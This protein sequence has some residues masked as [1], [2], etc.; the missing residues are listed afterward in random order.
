MPDGSSCSMGVRQGERRESVLDRGQRNGGQTPAWARVFA[1]AATIAASASPAWADAAAGLAWLRA[2]QSGEGD[3]SRSTGLAPR[4]S[5]EA[6][7]TLFDLDHHDPD[8][9]RAADALRS[10]SSDTVDL[11]ARR[12]TSLRLGLPEVILE[13]ELQALVSAG[14]AGG[15]WGFDRQA[16]QA[17]ALDTALALR[18]LVTTRFLSNT[19]LLAGLAQLQALQSAEGGFSQAQGEAADVATTAEVL[20]A[21]GAVGVVRDVTALRERAA[22]FLIASMNAD[23]GFPGFRGESSDPTMTALA[24]SALLETGSDVSALAPARAYLRAAQQSDGSWAGDAYT[25]ALAVRVLGG[26]KADLVLQ[27]L[28]LS[29]ASVQQGTPVQVQVTVRNAGLAPSTAA[30]LSLFAGD[31]SSN[32]AGLG[33]TQMPALDVGQSF[34][35]TFTVQTAALSGTVA[36]F[37][38]A[39][40]AGFVPEYSETNNRRFALL[41]VRPLGTLPDPSTNQ[42]PIITNIAPSTAISGTLYSHAVDAIDPESQTLQYRLVFHDG[43]PAPQGMVMDSGT[44]VLT[45]MAGA[46]GVYA[47]TIR[48]L[49]PQG[50][51]AVQ[52]VSL[53]VL[54][55]GEKRPPVFESFPLTSA[56]PGLLYAYHVTARDPDGGPLT[57]RLATAPA[58]MTF[59][60]DTST[61]RWTPTAT[62]TGE[63]LVRLIATDDEGT[64]ADQSWR[65]VVDGGPTA[66][67]DLVAM[68]VD[69]S[70]RRTDRQNLAVGGT[71]L[72]TVANQGTAAAPAFGLALYEDRDGVTGLSAQDAVV[73]R[74]TVPGLAPGETT[75]VT[76][77]LTGT[78]LF[79]DNRLIL[80]VDPDHEVRE[81]R[82]DNNVRASGRGRPLLTVPGSFAP[83]LKLDHR[84]I[85][86]TDNLTDVGLNSPVLVAQL[87]DDN[88]DGKIGEGDT[89]DLLYVVY[90]FGNNV[91]RGPR[92]RAIN[93][94][95]GALIFQTSYLVWQH[96][97]LAVGDVD[98]DGSPDIFAYV[99][100]G[101]G[102]QSLARI[103]KLGNLVWTQ[104]QNEFS[105]PALADLDGDGISEIIAGGNIFEANGTLRCREPH[106]GT[107]GYNVV[108]ADLDLDG[109]PEILSGYDVYRGDCSI[110]RT[111]S[112]SEGA[113]NGPRTFNAVAQLDDDPQPEIIQ[114][115]GGVQT[116]L[117]EHDGTLK[118]TFPSAPLSGAPS[119]GDLD[120]DGKAEIV[121]MGGDRV[122]ALGANGVVRWTHSNLD[123]TGPTLAFS[124]ADLDGDGRMEAML[125]EGGHF[126]IVRGTDGA[127][128]FAGQLFS[129]TGSEYITVADADGDGRTD[130]I[131]GN[132]ENVNSGA[133]DARGIRVWGDPRWAAARPL[134]NQHA[135]HV[136][137]IGCDQ[138]MPRHEPPQWQLL[139]SYLA[140]QEIPDEFAEELHCE[141]GPADL[142]VSYIRIDR[143]A[144]AAQVGY[145]VRVG[146]GGNRTVRPGARV[147]F[148]HAAG[149]GDPVSVGEVQ[150]TRTLGPGQFEDVR[151]TTAAPGVGTYTIFAEIA[152]GS[153]AADDP[154]GNNSHATSAELCGVE[155]R[156]P[157][158]TSAPLVTAAVGVPYAY[159]PTVNDPDQD[160]TTLTLTTAPA[161][162]QLVD[163]PGLLAWTPTA[164]QVGPHPVTLQV[165]DGRGGLAVQDFVVVVGP[166]PLPETAP[167]D[168]VASLKLQASTDKASYA[169]NETVQVSVRIDNT[170]GAGRTGTLAVE[171]RDATGA[172]IETLV[173][174][175]TVL[176]TGTGS[177][178]FPATF[179]VGVRRPGTL[180]VRASYT[181]G[182]AQTVAMSELQILG[183][184]SV[185]ALV[186]TDK[187]VY[188][189]GQT[190]RVNR[191]LTNPGP[192]AEEAGLVALVEVVDASNN[193]LMSVP[194]PPFTLQPGVTSNRLVSFATTGRPAG[195]YRARL[196]V[197]RAGADV[198]TDETIFQIQS[199]GHLVGGLTV[200]PSS[201]QIGDDF[202]LTGQLSNT[203]TAPLALD[204]VV[205]ILDVE[206]LATVRQSTTT[207]SLAAGADGSVSATFSSQGLA[208]K[209][210]LATIEL[211]ENG[212]PRLL[213]LSE[214]F[215]VVDEQP[216]V[217][218]IDIPACSHSPLTPIVNVT[219]PTLVS[220]TQLLDGAPYDGSPVTTEATHV[221]AV[222]ARD[223]AG[224]TSSAS[225]SF[226]VDD[227]APVIGV[228]GVSD[229]AAYATAVTPV[230][231]FDDAN[232]LETTL[233]LD[234]QPFASGAAVEGEGDHTLLATAQDCA[235]NPA[236]RQVQFQIDRTAPVVTIEVP[237]CS[238]GPVTPTITVIEAHVA[239]DVRKLDGTPY[240]G[241][242]VTADGEHEL[243]VTVTDRAGNTNPEPRNA[244]FTVDS[245]QPSVTISGVVDGATYDGPV[246]PVIQ[247][248]DSHLTTSTIVLNG[249][250]FDSGT[251]VSAEGTYTL[252]VTAVDCAGNRSN[253]SVTFTIRHTQGFAGELSHELVAGARVLVATECSSGCPPAPAFLRSV[254]A[255]NQIPFEQANGRSEWLTKL[256]S[257]RFNL[258]V[259]YR[260]QTLESETALRELNEAVW[261]GD[262]LVFIK[263]QPDAMPRLRES[264]GLDFQGNL[265]LTSA[266]LTAPL[267]PASVNVTGGGA[268]LKLSGARGLGVAT[269]N[270]SRTVAASNG[271]GLGKSV[272]LAWNAETSAS[273]PLY[274]SALGIAAPASGGLLPG[275]VAI[276]RANVLNKGPTTTTFTVDHVLGAGLL[277]SDPLTHTLT[278]VPTDTGTFQLLLRLPFQ[279]GT[280]TLTGT[281]TAQGQT[282]DTDVFSMQVDRSRGQIKTD[283]VTA[284]QNL[285]L[286]GGQA[287]R[288]NSA[289]SKINQAAQST[290]AATAIGLV[291]DAIEDV[292]G[293]TAVDVTAIR[294]DLARLLRA[295]QLGWQP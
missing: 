99:P 122:Y 12:L 201:V 106:S 293:I 134:W 152:P 77:T 110:V 211:S 253:P 287:T 155:N 27:S 63:Q 78:G 74:A 82:E 244:L 249:A 88:G 259:L 107:T 75:T 295:H 102:T 60:P 170:S 7:R 223:G 222:T 270:T 186:T 188:A 100:V 205:S 76:V 157:V 190:V 154:P 221:L 162:M 218:S 1:V 254:L 130:L 116:R 194:E 257:G 164:A 125:M 246:V 196:V 91:D 176:F 165:S 40:P 236:T 215:T 118:W 115:V 137:N 86:P 9:V 95:T 269:G 49:D 228:S 284:L 65:V 203:G 55:P 202:D 36:L 94:R 268:F 225:V 275:G 280:F 138:T 276:V 204:A 151:V 45:W 8:F 104:T 210:Y 66:S 212:G 180:S 25:T 111:V 113:Q 112:T 10:L 217:I 144:C 239:S 17:D 89:P 206:T 34:T 219:D 261:M 192:N 79:A 235:S 92:L 6:A 136:T 42:A 47:F 85:S 14:L 59:D 120:G 233:T 178:T 72:A 20:A 226:T 292:R 173:Q 56:A 124:L 146:N 187:Q 166:A 184:S 32:G 28:S 11:E 4:D 5:A 21:L 81:L 242:P 272:T 200:S 19:A 248:T 15:G 255:D 69:P 195:T 53:Q 238:A 251:M 198:A 163:P 46:P 22:T 18:A 208:L 264:L 16:R 132:N 158:F 48:V 294:I 127:D 35:H 234:G 175:R 70:L 171:I 80:A 2:H 189:P 13:S 38:V 98:A 183:S 279:S 245:V 58:G 96:S 37:A 83:T 129:G 114:V 33:T 121:F 43:V 273:A 207:V 241:A 266:T 191:R 128:L 224:S 29:S 290:D 67:I 174:D 93:G 227:T 149:A 71:A 148:K 250:P 193:Q 177:Q 51:S 256:R 181:E 265:A 117:L 271:V 123:F 153:A 168:P 147:I 167:L 258:F 262:G 103:D 150:T 159:V 220:V 3:W 286:S 140:S 73:G 133:P 142:S 90:G 199:V 252:A 87:N 230:V 26:E 84:R 232:A 277:T 240:V 39:D 278:V 156:Q 50:A 243:V 247:V 197:Q 172:L 101:G 68:A 291:L 62:Q 44:G 209:R 57:M 281:L 267:Q 109:K 41:V 182:V 139:N 61:V 282:L 126:F 105:A 213:T 231:T 274:L 161:G 23:G 288:R 260:P 229:G 289:V 179:A 52:S 285:T 31:P 54:A 283:I 64:S 24:M 135:Y 97:W 143:S 169:A 108:V 119:V 160:F 237:R 145:V 131:F 141:K 263:E 214:T 30:A 185:E 216:P